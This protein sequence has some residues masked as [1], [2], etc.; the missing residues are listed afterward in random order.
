MLDIP[1]L[2]DDAIA[3]AKCEGLD[4]AWV[5][6]CELG[7]EMLGQQRGLSKEESGR[8][9]LA[10]Y[11]GVDW[12]G[13]FKDTLEKRIIEAVD[14]K[15][16]VLKAPSGEPISPD[17]ITL[18][19]LGVSYSSFDFGT[20]CILLSDGTRVPRARLV[21]AEPVAPAKTHTKTTDKRVIERAVQAVLKG[22]MAVGK[23][24]P[25]ENEIIKPVNDRL[26]LKGLLPA[27]WK[28]IQG[29]REALLKKPPFADYHN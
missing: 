5:E 7:Y 12:R 23:K 28:T 8:A 10:E 15:K 20:G 6:W 26:E 22:A 2:V 4:A 24:L 11:G 19:S 9:L 21:R 25:N 17:L 29:L 13:I 27:E 16:W 3:F 18:W 14:S 1:R